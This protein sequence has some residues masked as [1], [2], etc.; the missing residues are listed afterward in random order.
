MKVLANGGINLSALDGWWAEAYTPEVG[1]AL[2]DGREHDPA[3][4]SIEAEALYDLLEEKVGPEFYSRNPGGIPSAWVA[5]MRESMARLTPQFSA[6][7]TVRQYT[8]E[9]YLPAA[10]AY[11]ARSEN[12]G[13]HGTQ[14]LRWR[15]ALAQ[16][17]ENVRFGEVNVQTTGDKHIFA[18]RV[19]LAELNPAA[20]RVEL[21]ADATDKNKPIRQEM[22]LVRPLAA[23]PGGC[24][25][26]AEVAATRPASDYTARLM[27]HH[28]GMTLPV[29]ASLILWQR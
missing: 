7:R 3:W 10:T 29:E 21:F 4:D 25:Y 11:R 23:V 22:K 16:Q 5:R 13:A 1:W 9:Y 19:H 24:L 26:T 28:P 8:T 20:V 6:G 27:P 12:K 18:V 2:G 14:L 17:W 15:Q